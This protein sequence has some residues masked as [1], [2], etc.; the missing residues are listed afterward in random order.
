[1]S[2]GESRAWGTTTLTEKATHKC[3]YGYIYIWTKGDEE[4]V[5]KEE[6]KSHQS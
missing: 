3:T 4:E 6:R 5:S 2:G 1:M